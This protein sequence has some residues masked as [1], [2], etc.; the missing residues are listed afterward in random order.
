MQL[1]SPPFNASP[2][3]VVQLLSRQGKYFYLPRYQ[4]PYAWT[5]A[6]LEEFVSDVNGGLRLVIDDGGAAKSALTFLGAAIFL[7]TGGGGEA[8]HP[9]SNQ[10]EAPQD[11]AV[12]IDGQQRLTTL[13]MTCAAL[14][15]QL[16]VLLKQVSG[17][18]PPMDTVVVKLAKQLRSYLWKA[19][20]EDRLGTGDNPF[21]YYPRMIRENDDLWSSDGRQAC[22]RSPIAELLHQSL[23]W[24]H[25]REQTRWSPEEGR[26]ISFKTTEDKGTSTEFEACYKGLCDLIDNVGKGK[27]ELQSPPADVVFRSRTFTEILKCAPNVVDETRL[28]AWR[29]QDRAP[30]GRRDPMV[31]LVRTAIFA[32]YLRHRV[33]VTE[34]TAPDEENAFDLFQALNTRGEP[35]TAYETFKPVVMERVPRSSAGFSEM[36]KAMDGIDNT[37]AD[38]GNSDREALTQQLLIFTAAYESGY[39]LGKNIREQRRWLRSQLRVEDRNREPRELADFVLGIDRVATAHSNWTRWQAREHGPG[40]IPEG[41][42]EG[43]LAAEVLADAKHT[44]V[45]PIL[46]PFISVVQHCRAGTEDQRNSQVE[47][48]RVL[49]ALLATATLWRLAHGGTEG[50]DDALRA[51]MSSD[52]GISRKQCP[53]PSL[54]SISATK[55]IDALRARLTGGDGKPDLLDASVWMSLAESQPSYIRAPK[56]AKIALAAAFHKATTDRSDPRILVDSR[57]PSRVELSDKAPWWEFRYNIEHL[58]PQSRGEG[59]LNPE[60]LHGLGNLTLVPTWVNSSLSDKEWSRKR[61]LFELMAEKSEIDARQF[62]DRLANEEL[63]ER[64]DRTSLER[65]NDEGVFQDIAKSLAAL[66]GE[67]DSEGIRNRGKNL[68]QRAHARLCTWL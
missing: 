63:L 35:L 57:D 29:D 10:A 25:E 28:S 56:F 11:I 34:V 68:L 40:L 36:L 43:R 16:D 14:T 37:I 4:R 12:V 44:V 27:Q 21:H 7:P 6:N 47:L 51:V 13:L 60:L 64:S 26:R 54:A 3:Q 33:Y 48:E 8:I 46:T 42:H 45:L 24:V 66:P 17:D 15:S 5:R 41:F 62:V 9:A 61:R 50:I 58:V 20:G 2:V 55:V 67:L 52:A 19:L 30:R 39:K 22:Y 31:A 59:S 32:E 23:A 65:I 53:S 18:L 38:A 1:S 49:R